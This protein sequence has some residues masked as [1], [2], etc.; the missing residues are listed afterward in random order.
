MSEK[1][2]DRKEFNNK[3]GQASQQILHKFGFVYLDWIVLEVFLLWIGLDNFCILE[4]NH[5]SLWVHFGQR[6]LLVSK[7][8]GSICVWNPRHWWGWGEKGRGHTCEAAGRV[9]WP[10]IPLQGHYN[11]LASAIMLLAHSEWLRM[12]YK[13]GASCWYGDNV[14]WVGRDLGRN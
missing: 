7:Y 5:R 11:C 2:C 1:V 9:I 6:M 12:F 3:L 14:W 8:N 10:R 13:I 4:R